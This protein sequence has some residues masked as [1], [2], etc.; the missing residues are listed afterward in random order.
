M[1][2]GYNGPPMTLGNAASAKVRLIASCKACGYRAEPNV[3]ALAA[4][5]GTNFPVPEWMACPRCSRCG[6][7]DVDAVVS[8]ARR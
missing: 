6:S 4:A 7:R 2:R 3:D 5:L 1:T 8:G